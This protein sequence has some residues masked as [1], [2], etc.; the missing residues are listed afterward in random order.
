MID[1][2]GCEVMVPRRITQAWSHPQKFYR[3]YQRTCFAVLGEAGNILSKIPG[4]G[5]Q[6]TTEPTAAVP[7]CDPVGIGVDVDDARIDGTHNLEKRRR[8]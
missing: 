2:C 5:A 8:M 1:L 3:F 7:R 4:K 6:D